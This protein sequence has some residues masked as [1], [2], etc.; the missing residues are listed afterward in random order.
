MGWTSKNE[1]FS[2]VEDFF[3]LELSA[4]N[5]PNLISLDHVIRGKGKNKTI[6]ELVQNT[7]TNA[8]HVEQFLVCFEDGNVDYKRTMPDQKVPKSFVKQWTH[9]PSLKRY[10]ELM[11]EN[12]E[13]R[14]KKKDKIEALKS[15]KKGEVLKLK[16][17]R[18]VIFVSTLTNLSFSCTLVEDQEK[19][20]YS[21]KYDMVE[22]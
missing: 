18:A 11:E 16:D 21:C 7:E 19:K 14:K 5:D 3:R 17:G 22:T 10:L 4:N 15:T 13:H 6:V 8:V 2:S 20:I 1:Q 9:E 12:K